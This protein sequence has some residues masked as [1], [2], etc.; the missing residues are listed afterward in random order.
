MNKYIK[1]DK[2]LVLI[3]ISVFILLTCGIAALCCLQSSVIVYGISLS[4][5]LGIVAA[6]AFAVCVIVIIAVAVNKKSIKRY[7]I[8]PFEIVIVATL[9]I[10]L[11]P[12][13]FI[14]WIVECICDKI[15]EKSKSVL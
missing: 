11:S 8:L 6:V 5:L 13:A 2:Y 15:R 10:A 12:L 1:S 14:V 7:C 9:L 3:C 4:A